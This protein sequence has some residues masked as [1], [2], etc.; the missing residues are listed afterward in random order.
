L[1]EP[2]FSD[3]WE[4]GCCSF[5]V[6]LFDLLQ[7]VLLNEICEYAVVCN[8][9]LWW[10]VGP[11]FWLECL[12]VVFVEFVDEF[13]AFALE[14]FAFLSGDFLDDAL[15]VFLQNYDQRLAVSPLENVGTT[16]VLL[17]VRRHTSTPL[18]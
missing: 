2:V 4:P 18:K 12:F 15:L 1:V 6:E 3:C 5:L 16:D 13:T 7:C 14:T 9:V 10:E 17:G 8:E 11:F